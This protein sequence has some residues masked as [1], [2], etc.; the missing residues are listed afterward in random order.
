[1]MLMA[2]ADTVAKKR[3]TARI[4]AAA[5]VARVRDGLGDIAPASQEARAVL[6]SVAKATLAQAR[7]DAERELVA[8]HKGMRCAQTLARA[9]DEIIRAV[10]LWATTY[11]FPRENPSEA[12]ALA[13]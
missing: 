9:E 6:L 8:S 5:I 12:E 7:K 2:M 11:V 3:Q 1:M 4:D 13:I 10:H